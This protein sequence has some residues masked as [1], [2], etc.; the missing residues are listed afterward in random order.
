MRRC[1]G[2]PVRIPRVLRGSG[3]QA[4]G[5]ANALNT[6]GQVEPPTTPKGDLP[7]VRA[8]KAL[9]HGKGQRGEGLELTDAPDAPCLHHDACDEAAG[10][11]S[12]AAAE[13]RRRALSVPQ[14]AGA[15]ACRTP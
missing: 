14:A 15:M 9:V 1:D 2:A 13:V 5:P 7:A 3:T 12:C 6:G 10:S 4:G 11:A 8:N